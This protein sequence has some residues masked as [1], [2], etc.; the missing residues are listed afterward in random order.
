MKI[1][2]FILG[3]V[4]TIFLIA[5][6]YFAVFRRRGGSDDNHLPDDRYPLW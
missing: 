2:I 5:F 3:G 4:F 1:W 6:F